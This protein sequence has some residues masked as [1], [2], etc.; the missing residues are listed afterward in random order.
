M[1]FIDR[2]YENDLT[3]KSSLLKIKYKEICELMDKM[4][5]KRV[6]MRSQSI[7]EILERK[8]VWALNENENFEQNIFDAKKE[9]NKVLNLKKLAQKSTRAYNPQESYIY[10]ML[11]SKI[12]E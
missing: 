7:Q 9:L 1:P 2:V 12:L 10:T 4:T 8:Q 6:A 3:I 11:R 5:Q